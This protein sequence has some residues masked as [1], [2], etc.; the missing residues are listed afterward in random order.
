EGPGE[1]DASGPGA[2]RGRDLRHPFPG[3]GRD[4]V[5]ARPGHELAVAALQPARDPARRG[6]L[7]PRRLRHQQGDGRQ[8]PR[9]RRQGH[10]LHKRRQLGELAAGQG[11][12]PQARPRQGLLRLVLGEVARHKRSRRPRPD[13]GG[14]DGRVQGEGLRRRGAGQ[15]GRLPEQD[16]L[17]DHLRPATPLQ[18]VPGRGRPREGPRDRHE[19]RP[20]P[21]QGP[22]RPLRLRHNRGLLRMEMV[23]RDEPVYRERQGRARRRVHRYGSEAG[24]LL[25]E[26][27]SA[28]VRR[29]PEEAQPRRLAQGLL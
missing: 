17:Q 22:R 13:H 10:L 12:V 28:R 4:A 7:R 19:E 1:G 21:G 20:R 9:Q 27:E 5:A 14:Q 24:P 29:H 23:R 25:P 2:G 16:G 18:H 15:H 8:D 6:R 3:A 11:A 26:S